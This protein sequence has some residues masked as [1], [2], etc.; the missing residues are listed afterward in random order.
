M[1]D[2]D[3][4]SD[5]PLCALHFQYLKENETGLSIKSKNLSMTSPELLEYLCSFSITRINAKSLHP[6][7]HTDHK[8]A[9]HQDPSLY[10]SPDQLDSQHYH[11]AFERPIP[12]HPFC[13]TVA[14]RHLG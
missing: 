13:D 12:V 7:K 2:S 1:W 10:A 6:L 14:M 5:S 9:Y 8:T 4:K 11:P 3:H